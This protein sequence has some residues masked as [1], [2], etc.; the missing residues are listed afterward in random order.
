MGSALLSLVGALAVIGA[1]L[2]LAYYATRLLAL[3]VPKGFA[4]ARGERHMQVLE[5]MPVARDQKLMVVQVGQRFF[6]LGATA[7]NIQT[8]AE[9]TP[10]EGQQWH[11]GPEEGAPPSFREALLSQL[12]KQ[13]KKERG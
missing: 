8:L 3:R 2:V 10:E 12:K 11:Q 4:M 1:M 13:G 6:L 9:L 7:N 5:Q